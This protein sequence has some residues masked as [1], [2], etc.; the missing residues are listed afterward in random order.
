MQQQYILQNM[1]LNALYNLI[2]NQISA[3]IQINEKLSR[4]S[5]YITQ[6]GPTVG[7]GTIE[8]RR[9]SP[10]KIEIADKIKV[11]LDK[12]NKGYVIS[13][14]VRSS[15]VRLGLYCVCCPNFSWA[16]LSEQNFLGSIICGP[17]CL[18]AQ[19]F[20]GSIVG[21]QLSVLHQIEQ[22]N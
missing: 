15:Q 6:R 3:Q 21:A 17:N 14:Q 20:A 2:F 22:K 9:L 12:A 5:M 7:P 1:R 8:P 19:V 11:K 18:R 16:Q 10:G 13:D 4:E